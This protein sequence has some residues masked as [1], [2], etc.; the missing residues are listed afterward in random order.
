MKLKYVLLMF[1]LFPAVADANQCYRWPL[2]SNSSGHAAYDGDTIY[3]TMPGLPYEIANMS[4]RVRGIDTAEI[5]AKCAREKMLAIKARDRVRKILSRASDVQFCNPEWGRYG[6]RVVAS[7][8]VG[9]VSLSEI[10]IKEGLARR[11]DGHTARSSW[12]TKGE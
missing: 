12:C 3:I 8:S 11:Y 1:M 9:G 5:R 10:L 2:R 7:V 6:G 4:V